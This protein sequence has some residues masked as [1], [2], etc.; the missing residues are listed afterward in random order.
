MAKTLVLIFAVALSTCLLVQGM[1]IAGYGQRC[2]CGK[3]KATRFPAGRVVKLEIYPESHRCTQKEVIVTLKT[4]T[5][6]C[7]DYNSKAVRPAI[8]GVL[9]RRLF[10][11]D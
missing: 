4:G 8:D 3:K 11:N 7:L 9:R 2:I 1:S 5:K 6:V 10:R